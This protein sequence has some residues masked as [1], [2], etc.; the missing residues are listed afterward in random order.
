MSPSDDELIE[1]F[2]RHL[3]LERG[4]SEHTTAAYG[5]DVSALA[6]FLERAGTSL[7]AAEYPSLRRWLAQQA[8]MGYA[9]STIARRAAAV[10][11]FY[12]FAARRGLVEANPASLLGSPKVPRMLPAVLRADEAATLVETPTAGDAWTIRDRA[13]L[14]LLYCAGLRVSEL[15][16]LDVRDVDLDRERLRVFGKGAKEREVP[17]GEAA[18]DALRAYL[19][20]ARDEVVA[21]A[22]DPEAVF[23]NRR[24]KRIGPREVRSLVERYRR[25]VAS[26][27]TISPH[28]LRHSFATHLMEGGADIRAVQ[29]LLGHASLTS[30]QRYTHV[31]RGRL[32]GAYRRSHPR[33]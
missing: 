10:R 26:G 32:F 23:H 24:R 19:G 5:R 25:G 31:S 18:A 27:R 6:T 16:G 14:E 1:A 7:T 12:R 13:I 8:T 22:A 21:G 17:L 9:R 3:R 33:A 28:T 2:L 15:C 30:T 20:G 4:L 29:E 11:A